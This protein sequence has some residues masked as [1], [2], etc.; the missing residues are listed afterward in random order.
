MFEKLRVLVVED[1]QIS[2]IL[3]SE[4]LTMYGHEAVLA[5]SGIEALD[6]LKNNDFDAV[7]LDVKLPDISGRDLTKRVRGGETRDKDIPIIAV[8]AYA[9]P[10]DKEE[11]LASGMDDYMSK[12]INIYSLSQ[13]V[14]SNVHRKRFH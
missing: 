9:L 5:S 1:N 6:Q 10:G 12:P 14:S 4:A 3:T 13:V 7:L 11:C 8:T 2:Q